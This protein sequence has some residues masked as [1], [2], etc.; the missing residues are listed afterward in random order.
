M[1]SREAKSDEATEN[2]LTLTAFL[3]FVLFC[4]LFVLGCCC[5][6]YW[7]KNKVAAI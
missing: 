2:K 7:P 5:Y 4:F 6:C 1:S 3:S